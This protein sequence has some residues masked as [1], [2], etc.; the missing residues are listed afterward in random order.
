MM[1]GLTSS[2]PTMELMGSHP[3][4]G[5]PAS[6]YKEN[7]PTQSE[8]FNVLQIRED[9][10]QYI[11]PKGMT[12]S[13]FEKCAISSEK[14]SNCGVE[15]TTKGVKLSKC[16]GCSRIKYCSRSCQAADR[17]KHKP[18]CK[19]IIKEKKRLAV[20]T[21]KRTK[22]E[23]SSAIK[24]PNELGL[25]LVRAIMKGDLGLVKRLLKTMKKKTM[26]FN[27]NALYMLNNDN[28]FGGMVP[29]FKL[30]MDSTRVQS[31]T[32]LWI[33]CAAN[34]MGVV[35][36]LLKEKG[37]DINKKIKVCNISNRKIFSTPLEGASLMGH[38]Q[39]VNL[40]LESSAIDINLTTECGGNALVA[41]CTNGYLKVVDRLLLETD[42]I[43]MNCFVTNLK[44]QPGDGENPDF[45]EKNAI[46]FACVN[47]HVDVVKRM[48]C[49][50]NLAIN[51]KNKHGASALH[52]A[53]YWRH[54]EIAALLRSS[55]WTGVPGTFLNY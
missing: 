19:A 11:R 51:S 10:D 32:A 48:L 50:E 44:Y 25:H 5:I 28:F 47:G 8:F 41:A 34:R 21:K 54:H 45:L 30:T 53:L 46:M 20:N 2:E 49:E 14:C 1:T 35:I 16:G 9:D 36:R 43:D 37:I 38:V 22:A 23:V 26:A 42:T 12:K 6:A 29:T 27:I 40:L 13:T 4:P 31:A 39:I 24:S 3:I 55:G 17:S 18:L 15:A 7:P 33:A 52:I